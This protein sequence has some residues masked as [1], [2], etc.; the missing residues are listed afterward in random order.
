MAA[1]SHYELSD[2]DFLEHIRSCSLP[3]ALF[4]HDAHL[5]LA[6][7]HIRQSGKEKAIDIVKQQIKAFAKHIGADLFHETVSVAAVEK[8]NEYYICSQAE[9]FENFLL[10]NKTL[11]S[12]LRAEIQRHYSYD[13]FESP[14]AKATY[15]PPDLYPFAK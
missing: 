14:L 13:I 11:Q 2:P 3:A 6:W 10:E 9:C 4:T 12:D 5:R 1:T 8:V 15:M 7:L